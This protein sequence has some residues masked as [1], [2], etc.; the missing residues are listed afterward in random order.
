MTASVAAPT[1]KAAPFVFP[2]SNAPTI[3]QSWR[4]GPS[5]SIGKPKSFGNWL[6]NTVSAMPFMYP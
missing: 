3:A 2:A 1:A 4:N 5:A 6:I